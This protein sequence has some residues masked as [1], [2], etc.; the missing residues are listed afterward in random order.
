MVEISVD[1]DRLVRLDGGVTRLRPNIVWEHL[2]PRLEQSH[3]R[4]RLKKK[5]KLLKSNFLLRIDITSFSF[6]L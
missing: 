3:R 5:R 6:L 1:T 4:D 2:L